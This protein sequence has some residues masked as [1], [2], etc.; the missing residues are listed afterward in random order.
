MK[1][2]LYGDLG[3]PEITHGSVS[4]NCTWSICPPG[5][6]TQQVVAAAAA[7]EQLSTEAAHVACLLDLSLKIMAPVSAIVSG[8]AAARTN[9]AEGKEGAMSFFFAE[10]FEI[11]CSSAYGLHV[12]IM[13]CR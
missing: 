6:L 11:Q 2:E 12:E 3:A 9:N 13:I 5:R 7:V 4:Q 1:I 10:T 8:N